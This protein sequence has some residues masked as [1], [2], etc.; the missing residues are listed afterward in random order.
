M[1]Q[2]VFKSG[3]IA[4]ALGLAMG[5]TACSDD[6]DEMSSSDQYSGLYGSESLNVETDPFTGDSVQQYAGL[7]ISKIYFTG[8]GSTVRD[9]Y[10]RITNNS[11]DTIDA[12]G[13]V[14]LESKFTCATPYYDFSDSISDQHF[15]TEVVYQIPVSTPI[16][17]DSSIV[18][19]YQNTD[20]SGGLNLIGA[21]YAWNNGSPLLD[22]V[23][24]Y[25]ATVWVLHNRGFRSYAIGVLPTDTATFLANYQYT[26]TYK[27][28]VHNDKVDTTYVMTT[29]NAYFIPNEWII[30]AVNVVSPVVSERVL[31]TLPFALDE[32]LTWAGDSTNSSSTTRFGF[33]VT[34]ILEG[35]KF[36]DSN[37]SSE[38]FTPN[39][40][41]NNPFI[42]P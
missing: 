2:K 16:P 36:L 27:F 30:D 24:S 37:N 9:Q 25:S 8:S 11:N 34:R 1:K 39:D 26:G 18:L 15:V 6:F 17:P 19:A 10:F 22:K 13:V 28:D 33:G 35:G 23:F 5:W 21:D 4:A 20:V 42:I 31:Q 40:S 38:D 12:N 32:G 7:V 14:V 3:I 41:Q 29:T